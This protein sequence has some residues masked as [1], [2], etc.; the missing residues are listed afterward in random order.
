MDC[1]VIVIPVTKVSKEI[2]KF[3]DTY[4]PMNDLDHKNWN[5]CE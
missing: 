2:D 5:A 3:D 4:S 1:S